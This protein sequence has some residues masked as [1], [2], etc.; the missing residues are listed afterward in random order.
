MT[1]RKKLFIALFSLCITPSIFAET[2]QEKFERANQFF[3]LEFTIQVQKR[4]VHKR[5]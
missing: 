2:M 4:R 3:D 5:V 1:F